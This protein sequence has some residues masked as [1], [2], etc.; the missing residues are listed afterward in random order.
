[1]F[2]AGLL[3]VLLACTLLL[4]S[5]Q[6]WA[7]R[8]RGSVPRHLVA[9]L[10][11]TALVSAALVATWGVALGVRGPAPRPHVAL[12][13]DVVVAL[14]VAAALGAG[15]MHARRSRGRML[16]ARRAGAHPRAVARSAWVGRAAVQGATLCVVGGVGAVAILFAAV[17][18]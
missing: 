12:I 7:L 13:L 14:G 15:A 5:L 10:L 4:S 18:R 16:H 3:V 2:S 11:G 9:W 8:G 17:G 1:M 6:G